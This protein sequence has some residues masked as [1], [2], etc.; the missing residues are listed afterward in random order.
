MP[1][2]SIESKILRGAYPQREEFQQYYIIENHSQTESAQHFGITR[3]VVQS[4]VEF[5]GLVKTPEKIAATCAQRARFNNRSLSHKISTGEYP[6]K[7]SFVD[8][9][10]TERHSRFETSKHFNITEN[11]VSNLIVYFDVQKTQEEISDT[12]KNTCLD[13]YGAISNLQLQE[14]KDR[15]RK[16]CMD[17]YGVEH[18]SQSDTVRQKVKQ[19]LV[20]KYGVEHALQNEQIKNKLKN[21]VKEKYGIEWPCQLESCRRGANGS[22]SGPNNKFE[23][24]LVSEKI[25]FSR[26]FPLKQYSFDFKINNTL[27][28]IDPW[29]THQSTFKTRFGITEKKYHAQKTELAKENGFSCVHVF[30][31]DDPNKIIQTLLIK[32]DK[33]YAR[34]CEIRPVSLEAEREFLNKY[35][36][37]G[38]VK[39]DICL[40]LYFNNE[41]VEVMSFGKPR[42]NKA[43][44]YELLRL[45][46][47]KRVIGGAEKI[48]K[49]FIQNYEVTSVISYCDLSKF[50]G[51]VY[52]KLG[53]SLLRTAISKHWYSPKL[54]KHITD[55]LLRAQGFDR[56]LGNLFGCFGHGSDNQTLMIE[57]GFIEVYDAGQATYVYNKK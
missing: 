13:K 48:F 34:E 30:D 29:Y 4:L 24:R 49:N 18:I 11:A 3:P 17:K 45:C 1:R 10:V 8:Y 43:Y 39:S 25:D 57:H 5:W 38:Y 9:Y 22:S 20:A 28:E 2:E 26:E 33:C 51:D 54:K 52:K 6:D 19:T 32:K 42:Y 41:L 15:I 31:W 53:F 16:T 21:T 44:E 14:T 37:Q 55:N 56:L 27:V 23:Q 40:G 12:R 50:N 7:Q 35:H 46:S 36:L 47:S